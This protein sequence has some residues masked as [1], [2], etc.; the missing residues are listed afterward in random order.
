MLDLFEFFWSICAILGG[1]MLIFRG[2]WFLQAN[3]RAF[4]HLRRKSG[5]QLF[6]KAAEK[7][8]SNVN[9]F[10]LSALGFIFFVLGIFRLLN[11]I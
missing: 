9:I 5:I 2:K 7:E 4:T 1:L 10:F 6:K 11:F 3:I 8:Q